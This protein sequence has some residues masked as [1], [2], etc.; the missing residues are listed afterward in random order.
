MTEHNIC[1]FT[2]DSKPEEFLNV[3]FKAFIYFSS[4]F[5]LQNDQT[6]AGR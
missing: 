5:L 3:Y 4:V 6:E 1:P 2:H